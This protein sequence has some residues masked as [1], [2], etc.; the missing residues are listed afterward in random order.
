MEKKL[1][2]IVTPCYNEEGN[3]ASLYEQVKFVIEGLLNKYDYEHIFIDNA[4]SDN[5]VEILK[6]IAKNDN[7]V[8][9]IVNSRNFGH[10]RSPVY[11]MMQAMGDVVI[12]LVADL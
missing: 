4:S 3:V 2:S 10:I 6:D 11:A 8:K 1:I 9:I 7:N 12:S 5:T